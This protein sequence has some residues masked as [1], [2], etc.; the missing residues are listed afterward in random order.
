MVRIYVKNAD[1]T[2]RLATDEEIMTLSDDE[3]Y[4]DEGE[5]EKKLKIE[6]WSKDDQSSISSV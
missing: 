2:T 3:L 6:S 5:I 1:G 4:L